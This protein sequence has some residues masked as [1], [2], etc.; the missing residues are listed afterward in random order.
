MKSGSC[1]V[2]VVCVCVVCEYCE[3]SNVME[4]DIAGVSV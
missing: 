3:M 1:E 4:G 2:L